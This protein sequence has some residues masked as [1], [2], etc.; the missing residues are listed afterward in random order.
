M[1]TLQG[2]ARRQF[3]GVEEATARA[4]RELEARGVKFAPLDQPAFREAVPPFH[5]RAAR[6]LKVQDLLAEI[7][8]T[9]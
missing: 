4:L 3:E 6:L 8:G 9:R 5:E 7:E 2:A 1:E